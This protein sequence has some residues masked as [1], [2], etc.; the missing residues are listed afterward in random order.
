MSF[1]NYQQYTLLSCSPI[2][3]FR[4]ALCFLWDHQKI[5][6]NLFLVN[7]LKYFSFRELP[8]PIQLGLAE[9]KLEKGKE[10]QLCAMCQIGSN[11][12]RAKSWHHVLSSTVNTKATMTLFYLL[13]LYYNTEKLRQILS[14]LVYL[15]Y[16]FPGER[17]L[18]DASCIL[19]KVLSR[20]R[21]QNQIFV[22]NTVYVCQIMFWKEKRVV[23]LYQQ[24]IICLRLWMCSFFRKLLN[25]S[26]SWI[27][28]LDQKKI[29]GLVSGGPIGHL[30]GCNVC[31][32]LYRHPS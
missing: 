28:H 8:R 17:E 4:L 9:E 14:K 20:C 25:Y 27:M 12:L 6:L 15:F 13:I 31:A 7:F 32:L 16:C 23:L 21:I 24:H 1:Q 3:P 5:I 30:I 10:L 26:P 22:S 19:S 11:C 18:W 29:L 2:F